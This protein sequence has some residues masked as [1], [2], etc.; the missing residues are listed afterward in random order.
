[1]AGHGRVGSHHTAALTAAK[2][3]RQQIHPRLATSVAISHG[4]AQRSSYLLALLKGVLVDNR[5][6]ASRIKGHRLLALPPT[7]CNTIVGHYSGVEGAL[8]E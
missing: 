6:V 7:L 4:L 2:Q 8:Q 5:R 3:A 1:M